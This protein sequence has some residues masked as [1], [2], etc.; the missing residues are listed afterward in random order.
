MNVTKLSLLLQPHCGSM[1]VAAMATG[2]VL[3]RGK[4]NDVEC[5]TIVAT[6]SVLSILSRPETICLHKMQTS[7]GTAAVQSTDAKEQLLDAFRS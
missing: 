6:A 7:K 4:N 3:H 2:D 5:I 1:L